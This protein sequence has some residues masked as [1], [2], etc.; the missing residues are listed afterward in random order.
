[1]RK[2]QI[3]M[4]MS[5][6]K[7]SEDAPGRGNAAILVLKFPYFPHHVLPAVGSQHWS[8]AV[9]CPCCHPTQ[10]PQSKKELR[11]PA[12]VPDLTSYVLSFLNRGGSCSLECI[13]EKGS[14]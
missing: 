1:M 9:L 7:Q 8:C 13:L 5:G 12:L 6:L 10:A 3:G 2:E 4:K 14:I 11:S